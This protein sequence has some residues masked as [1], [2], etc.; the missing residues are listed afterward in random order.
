MCQMVVT[1]DVFYF[2]MFICGGPLIKL[3]ILMP[4]L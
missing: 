4:L 1:G 3:S 2:G